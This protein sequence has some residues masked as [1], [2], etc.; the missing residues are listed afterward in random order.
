[1]SGCLICLD[2][3][4]FCHDTPCGICEEYICLDCYLQ[5]GIRIKYE[6]TNNK[7]SYRLYLCSDN[8][9]LEKLMFLDRYGFIDI[10][11]NCRHLENIMDKQSQLLKKIQSRCYQNIIEKLDVHFIKN[12]SD[13]IYDY[14]YIS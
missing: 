8:C 10:Y 4:N 14:L 2:D 11:I 9:L 1:M 5:Y 12:L 7:D 13:I 6:V 3:R